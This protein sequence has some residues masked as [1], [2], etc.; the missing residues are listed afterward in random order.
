MAKFFKLNTNNPIW[1][2]IDAIVSM[3]YDKEENK[4]YIFS[5]DDPSEHMTVEGDITNVILNANNDLSMHDKLFGNYLYN[6]FKG[7]LSSVVARLDAIYKYTEKK[8]RN[9]K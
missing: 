3:Y 8:V 4:T 2:N 9:E 1:I 6:K 5:C 7:S